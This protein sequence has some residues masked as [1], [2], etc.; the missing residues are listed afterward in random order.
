MDRSWCYIES[1]WLC[2]SY[3]DHKENQ[4]EMKQSVSY[5]FLQTLSQYSLSWLSHSKAVT[6]PHPDLII[7]SITSLAWTSI[8]TRATIFCRWIFVKLP[9]I[10]SENLFSIE[11]CEKRLMSVMIRINPGGGEEVGCKWLRMRGINVASIFLTT[12]RLDRTLTSDLSEMSLEKRHILLDCIA[13][14]LSD[15][16]R[17]NH[18]EKK[19]ENKS[20]HKQTVWSTED[21]IKELEITIRNSHLL[22]FQTLQSFLVSS[23]FSAGQRFRAITCPL[24]LTGSYG[25][26]WQISKE[27]HYQR[28]KHFFRV[29]GRERNYEI[30]LPSLRLEHN[31]ALCLF[32]LTVLTCK[33]IKASTNL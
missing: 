15:K 8:V 4:S 21:A 31:K 22:L 10:I 6:S 28:S 29:H 19:K 24:H 5:S 32:D 9:R 23:F 30:K 16:N 11:I 18:K 20:K 25:Q 17:S 33:Y 27:P 13:F 7:F 14:R 3:K 1:F 2:Q 12:P 26:L